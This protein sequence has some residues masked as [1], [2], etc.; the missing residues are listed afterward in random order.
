MNILSHLAATMESCKFRE[1]VEGVGG[2]DVTK[3]AHDSQC[4]IVLKGLKN[5]LWL[6][7]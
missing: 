7:R 6:G 3:L 4:P 2:R 5:Y 1:R